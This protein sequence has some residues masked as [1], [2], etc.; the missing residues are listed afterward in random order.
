MT[1]HRRVLV[2][3]VGA[4]VAIAL[5]AAPSAA[6]GDEVAQGAETTTTLAPLPEGAGSILG[7]LPGQGVAPEDAG[8]RGGAGQIALFLVIVVAIGGG[9]LLVR[10]DMTKA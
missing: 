7:P 4:A 8:D 9:V 1:V 6:S 5:L 3:I 2:A 10:R